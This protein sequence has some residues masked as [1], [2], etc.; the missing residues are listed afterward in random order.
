MSE[1]YVYIDAPSLDNSD[2]S[3]FI[4]NEDFQYVIAGDSSRGNTA[5]FPLYEKFL[6]SNWR[7]S[8]S[9]N[10]LPRTSFKSGKWALSGDINVGGD[11]IAGNT[12]QIHISN[13]IV[14]KLL[15]LR[16]RFYK[17]EQITDANRTESFIH[18]E[19][20][21]YVDIPK[22]YILASQYNSNGV[23]IDDYKLVAIANRSEGKEY[24]LDR[25][26]YISGKNLTSNNFRL[27]FVFAP[28]N[29]GI[30]ISENTIYKFDSNSLRGFASEEVERV[31]I[32]SVPRG[33]LDNKSYI[34]Q[35]SGT[36]AGIGNGQNRLLDFDYFI[37]NDLIE[38]YLGGA[39]E[40]HHISALDLE[41][42]NIIK[43]SAP[44]V[45]N[46]NYNRKNTS[47]KKIFISHQSLSRNNVF[48]LTGEKI[49]SI[50][51]PFTSSNNP[52]DYENGQTMI[53]SQFNGSGLWHTNRVI[54]IWQGDGTPADLTSDDS[55]NISNG[56]V[57]S[58]EIL[59]FSY[60]DVPSVYTVTFDSDGIIYKG[61][62]LWISAIRPLG[63]NQGANTLAVHYY[64]R[65]NEKFA[66]NS[67]DKIYSTASTGG[68]SATANVKVIFNYKLRSDW[69][70]Y[71]EYSMGSGGA[72]GAGGTTIEGNTI[73][74]G[75]WRIAVNA[76]GNLEIYH[77]SATA[78]KDKSIFYIP[79]SN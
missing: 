28:V 9:T 12:A 31:G 40:K 53:N 58:R 36:N 37:D 10:S 14:G 61:K 48:S 68:F 54:W 67:L 55:A 33:P 56:W 63:E 25:D 17:K 41:A 39:S 15:K 4:V 49:I 8:I 75:D 27:V 5:E 42:L 74:L 77:T 44:S 3:K 79:S 18:D 46:R 24:I 69:F 30:N 76:E 78:D 45:N 65:D 34:C 64:E 2:Q 51:I 20:D 47:A 35:N 11:Y 38:E 57:K 1:S 60:F 7:N 73:N 71:I 26:F 22:V 13:F 21:D 32:R 19:I 6:N 66:Y 29:S 72:G 59:A 70:D 52:S 50:Q 62:G 43:Y 23:V 16:F